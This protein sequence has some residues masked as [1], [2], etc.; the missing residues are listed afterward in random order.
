MRA[1]AKAMLFVEDGLV[2]GRRA[3]PVCVCGVC[4]SPCCKECVRSIPDF[5]LIILVALP[6]F[7]KESYPLR[8]SWVMSLEELTKTI[9]PPEHQL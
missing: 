3:G 9:T 8:P 5:K 2:L 7:A 6:C 4:V 1:E